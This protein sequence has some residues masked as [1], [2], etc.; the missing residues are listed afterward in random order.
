MV[1]INGIQNPDTQAHGYFS[2]L[3]EW[4]DLLEPI[5]MPTMSKADD[6]RVNVAYA[7]D[8][9]KA[10]V[11]ADLTGSTRIYE[12]LGN[13]RGTSMVTMLTSW[14]AEICVQHDGKVVK[15]LGDGVLMTFNSAQ[16]AVDA[17]IAIQ[18]IHLTNMASYPIEL[19]MR[20]KVGIAYGKVMHGSDE[21]FG[22]AVNVAAGLC[23]L[24]GPDQILVNNAVV[25]AIADQHRFR[26][27]QIGTI[28]IPGRSTPCFAQRVEWHE[29]VLSGFLTVQAP[30]S[31][32]SPQDLQMEDPRIHLQ[33]MQTGLVVRKA[34]LPVFIGRD[35]NCSLVVSDQRVSRVHATIEWKN[36][37]FHLRD[38]S[39]YGTWVRYQE[40]ESVVALR[41]QGCP[42][43]G[44]GDISLGGPFNNAGVPTITF[45]YSAAQ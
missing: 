4:M 43:H 17:A 37:V 3:C 7:Q 40:N 14:L 25:N 45:A 41:R 12:S 21:C 2:A 32:V 27:R 22:D 1:L 39:S 10:V 33:F 28:A 35:E 5:G 6:V 29:D 20:I 24:A 36:S 16:R 26:L 8:V 38:K 31:V 19:L 42:L 34:D 23:D 13:R 11:F 15:T 30:L 18:R 9:L 44:N